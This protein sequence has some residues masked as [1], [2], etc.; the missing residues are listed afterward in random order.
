MSWTTPALPIPGKHFYL[1][2]KISLPIVVRSLR[3]NRFPV[4]TE[5]EAGNRKRTNIHWIVGF[6][7][8]K[9]MT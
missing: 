1:T 3:N 6:F 5:V 4:F 2:E 9:T 8:L 7:L